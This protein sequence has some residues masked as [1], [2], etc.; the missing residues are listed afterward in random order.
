MPKKTIL[1]TDEAFVIYDS[2]KP[3]KKSEYVSDAIVEKHEHDTGTGLEARLEDIEKRLER[4]EGR[5]KI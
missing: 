3:H 4:L 2:V 5:N 1:L